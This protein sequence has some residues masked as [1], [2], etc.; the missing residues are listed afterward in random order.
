[1]ITSFP[2]PLKTKQKSCLSYLKPRLIKKSRYIRNKRPTEDDFCCFCGSRDGLSTHEV[3]P[4][5]ANKRISQL[6]G[7]QVKV[8]GDCHDELQQYKSE[9]AERLKADTQREY[10]LTHSREAFMKLIGENYL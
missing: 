1:M 3:Y 2:K 7:F 8:C 10:E 9:K 5:T 6:N 4:G